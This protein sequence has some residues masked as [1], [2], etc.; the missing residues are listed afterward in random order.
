MSRKSVPRF[1]DN[2]RQNQSANAP[3][4]IPIE[5]DARWPKQFGS[6]GRRFRDGEHGRERA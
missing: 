6:G 1:C 2:D 3:H 5:G 4:L